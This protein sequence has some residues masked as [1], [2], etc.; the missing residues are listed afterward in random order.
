MNALAHNTT[1]LDNSILGSFLSSNSNGKAP[2]KGNR[3]PMNQIRY[4]EE[5]DWESGFHYYGARYY[6]SETLTGWLSVDPMADKYPS[7][8]PYA[9]CAWNPV[10]LVDPDGE[11]PIPIPKKF[12]SKSITSSAEYAHNLYCKAASI[13]QNHPRLISMVN[14]A[15]Y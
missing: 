5:G 6:W 4:S 8:S 7:I 15:L 14:D 9:Y 13:I 12:I 2:H 3:A 10:K 1:L 11:F